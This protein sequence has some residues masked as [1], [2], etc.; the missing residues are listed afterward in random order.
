LKTR[1]K[2]IDPIRGQYRIYALQLIFFAP[3]PVETIEQCS[4]TGDPWKSSLLSRGY[5][6]F[7]AKAVF[8]FSMRSNV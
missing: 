7:R 5:G 4:G 3:L 8:E 1:I 6:A 2:G